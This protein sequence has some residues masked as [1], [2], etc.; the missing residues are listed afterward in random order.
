MHD[1]SDVI[2]STYT[3]VNHP[4]NKRAVVEMLI[5]HGLLNE[6]ME[7]VNEVDQFEFQ[8][9]MMVAALRSGNW[10]MVLY[11]RSHDVPMSDDPV[12]VALSRGHLHLLK[13]LAKL[14]F[15]PSEQSLVLTAAAG[16]REMFDYLVHK[17]GLTPT[18]LAAIAAASSGHLFMVRHLH[19][20]YQ[21]IELKASL[22]VAAKRGHL[23][24]LEYLIEHGAVPTVSTAINSF[25]SERI[26]TVAYLLD[27]YP[28]LYAEYVHLIVA[29]GNLTIT[30]LA[31][32]KLDFSRF[33]SLKVDLYGSLIYRKATPEL[34]SYLYQHGF[35]EPSKTYYSR[36]LMVVKYH[37][38][39][40]I[41]LD[42]LIIYEASEEGNIDVI[43]YALEEGMKVHP[44][45]INV[46]IRNHQYDAFN[47]LRLVGKLNERALVYAAEWGRLDVVNIVLQLT[48][49]E[50][51]HEAISVA[52]ERGHHHIVNAL[53]RRSAI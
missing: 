49:G 34:M 31:M 40:G 32:E 27:R 11:L 16:Q 8:P 3:H 4:E 30:M 41:P 9:W 47:R 12:G 39:L 18:P 21:L 44:E 35:P 17:H 14:G 7:L 53:T 2:I 10:R 50:L 5:E 51:Y 45:D 13:S 23:E 25:C 20:R 46:A 38:Q 22:D 6:L 24:V 33:K 1:G 19:T 15:H 52:R 42:D 37:H 28:N 29:T 43:E 36:E 48:N 26:R